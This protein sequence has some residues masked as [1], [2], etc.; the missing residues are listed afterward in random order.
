MC[1]RELIILKD[2]HGP[3]DVIKHVDVTM[4]PQDIMHAQTGLFGFSINI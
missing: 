1:T 4:S 3:M 2:R